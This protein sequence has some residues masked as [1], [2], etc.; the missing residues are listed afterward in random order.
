MQYEILLLTL[1]PWALAAPPANPDE[2]TV[3]T[4]VPSEETSGR[5]P[6]V[7]VTASRVEPSG[8]P[9]V[10]AGAPLNTE[11]I[12]STARP[13]GRTTDTAGALSSV[14]GA[15]V[16]R[17][18]SQ[19]GMAQLRGLWGDRVRI[20]VDGMTVTPACPNHMDPPLHYADVSL[21]DSLTI[22]SG[23]TPVSQGGDSI[24]GTILVD[25][26]APRFAT[27]RN[28]AG[29]GGIAGFYNS[30]NDGFGGDAYGGVSNRRLSV[31]YSG[32]GQ[33]A[34][35]LRFPGG[36]VRATGYTTQQHNLLSA[37]RTEKGFWSVDGGL[38]RTRE[39]GTPA[40]PMDMIE[41]DAWRVGLKQR[42]AYAFGEVSTRLFYHHIDH[43]MDNYTLRPVPVA[44]MPMLSETTSDDT[45]LEFGLALPRD[46]HTFRAGT[47]FHL[48][49]FDAYQKNVRNGML[50]DTFNRTLRTR[51]GTYAEW[52]AD[53]SECW[54]TLVGVRNDNVISDADPIEQYMPPNRLD[55]M[56]FN[57][58]SRD[59]L[60][61]N[62][63]VTAAVRLTPNEW[64][65][66]ELGFARKNRAPSVVERYLWTP[67]S[68]SSGQAD[69]RTYLGKLD[70]NTETSHQIG[71]TGDWHGSRWQVRVSPF[72]NFVSDYIQG[73][74]IAR[75]D[76]AGRPVLQF[77]NVGRADLYGVDGMARYELSRHFGLR[78]QLSYVRGIN[79][80][81]DDNLYRIAPLRGRVGLDHRWGGWRNTIEV[82]LVDA[83]HQVAAYNDEPETPGYALLHLRTGYDFGDW[84]SLDLGLENVTDE[85]YTDHL[86]GINRVLG[87]DVAVGDR[88][89]GAGRFVYASV[90]FRF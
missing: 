9:S 45:G 3:G 33:T 88:I 86:A 55:A 36:R 31:A 41:D 80:D 44:R 7:V 25:A 30:S 66:Y 16:V 62:F 1:V 58:A 27:N 69:G 72:Y 65:A 47:G 24:A 75:T 74:P 6:E 34:G 32:S 28:V 64:S 5:M 84:C 29:F 22:M 2:D 54:T 46:L 73:T 70:L 14:P 12:A 50:Q 77:Q 39:A 68:A 85:Y 4:T 90:S 51:V 38:L 8:E 57:A 71:L 20:S 83:Q 76:R 67:L 35:D 48:N 18:G 61:V 82:E 17:N 15:A 63:D 59:A 11:V 81:N 52:Q 19:T 78:G 89:P 60:E 49:A 37:L 26:P 21:V 13:R 42:E 10:P 43:L 56:R 40:L 53:W 79:R 87:S 23:I